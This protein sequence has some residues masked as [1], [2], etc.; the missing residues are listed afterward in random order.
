MVADARQHR[1]HDV[2]VAALLLALHRVFGVQHQA[3]QHGQHRQHRL[4]GFGFQPVQP[5]LQQAD[6]AAELVD[7]KA[8]HAGAFAVA[9]AVQRAHQVGKHAALVDVGHQDHRAVHRFGKAHIGDVA[10]AQVDLGRAAGAFHHHH[11]VLRLQPPVGLQHGGHGGG[12]V[13]VVI[14]RVHV[15]AHLAVDDD[16]GAGVAAGLEQHRV[17]VGMRR[18]AGG[19]G[20]QRLGAADLAAVFGT[21]R[22]S[23]PCFAV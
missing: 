20:L 13:L 3:V 1:H 17:H 22:C 15:G 12:F 11:V 6:V 10:V 7:H 2:E 4:A 19:D 14:A 5:V 23:A 9:Q 21:P 18:Y 8:H 16:L